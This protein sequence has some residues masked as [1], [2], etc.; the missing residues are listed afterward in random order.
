MKSTP[1][2]TKSSFDNNLNL[3]PKLSS[4]QFNRLM[5]KGLGMT[6]NSR[7]DLSVLA[8]QESNT[9]GNLKIKKSEVLLNTINTGNIKNENPNVNEDTNNNPLTELDLIKISAENTTSVMNCFRNELGKRAKALSINFNNDY[10]K[11]KIKE[12]SIKA[13]NFLDNLNKAKVKNNQVEEKKI[14]QIYLLEKNIIHL[15]EVI[16]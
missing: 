2:Q 6:K 4:V 13:K 8:K 14:K 12:N 15:L 10:R 16:I 7:D 11:N 3:N 1:F 5:S 9:L